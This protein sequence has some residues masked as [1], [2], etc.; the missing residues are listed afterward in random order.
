[1]VTAAHIKA[2]KKW[3]AKVKAQGLCTRCVSRPLVTKDLCTVCRDVRNAYY[4]LNP[5]VPRKHCHERW[6]WLS[7]GDVTTKQ[8]T[9]LMVASDYKCHYCGCKVIPKRY[10]AKRPTGFD[11]ITPRSK[12]GKHTIANLVVCCWPCNHEK[13]RK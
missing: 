2:Q 7:Q 11:H 6:L 3:V 1:M 4:R 10:D 8:L 13:G 5:Q 9:E 12:G